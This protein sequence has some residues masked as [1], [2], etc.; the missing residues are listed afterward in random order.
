MEN[1][2][3]KIE[4]FFHTARL[5]K[6]SLDLSN[7]MVLSRHLLKMAI[8][9]GKPGGDQFLCRKDPTWVPYTLPCLGFWN[10]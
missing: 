4:N 9:Y 10:C 2:T 3:Y 6:K 8:L 5:C 1:L 7:I